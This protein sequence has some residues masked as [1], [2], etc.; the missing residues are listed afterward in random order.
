[1]FVP[2]DCHLT[3]PT[4]R[5]LVTTVL[6]SVAMTL[7]LLGSLYKGDHAVTVFLCHLFSIMPSGCIHEVASGR[8]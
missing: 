7:T 5:P 3:L 2:F 1:M 6:F 8:S 4:L